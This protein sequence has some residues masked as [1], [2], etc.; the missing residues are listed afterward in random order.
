MPH[1][2]CEVKELLEVMCYDDSSDS[3]SSDEE[4]VSFLLVRHLAFPPKP[5]RHGHICLEDITELD[6]EQLF[7]LALVVGIKRC[8]IARIKRYVVLFRI[9]LGLKKVI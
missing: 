9:Y 1:C 2:R 8:V 3:S 6:C 5:C 7:R 4:D